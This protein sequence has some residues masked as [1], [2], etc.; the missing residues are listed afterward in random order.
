[1]PTALEEIN[2]LLVPPKSPRGLS[3]PWNE[4]ESDLGLSL[5]DDYKSFIDIYGT[6]QITSA[7]GWVNVWNFRDDS[8][9]EPPLNA[10]LC[11]AGSVI[12]IYHSLESTDYPCPFPIFPTSGG[13][14]PFASVVDVQNL[15]WLTRNSPSQWSVV[16]FHSDGLEFNLLENDSFSQCIL[17]ML[18]N[19]YSGLSEPSSLEPPYEFTD[20]KRR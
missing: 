14:L 15:N 1:M 9:F 2:E 8:M 20:F 12:A 13:L 11:G 3:R 19:E 16:Y 10:M 6:G 5:P 17:K 4:V 18:R 7:D